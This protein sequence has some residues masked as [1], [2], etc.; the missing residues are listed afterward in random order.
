[1]YSRLLA[2]F[3]LMPTCTIFMRRL[4]ADVWF[5]CLAAIL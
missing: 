5:C 4:I 2:A 1:M 3:E